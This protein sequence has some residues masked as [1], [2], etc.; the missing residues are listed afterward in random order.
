MIGAVLQEQTNLAGVTV[1]GSQVK[2]SIATFVLEQ[3]SQKKNMSVQLLL[4][5][6][7]PFSCYQGKKPSLMLVGSTDLNVDFGT[8]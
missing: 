7:C 6:K 4:T 8:V 2:G 3:I 1:K 5:N